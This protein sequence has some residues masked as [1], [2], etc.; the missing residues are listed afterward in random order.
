M[1]ARV[2]QVVLGLVVLELGV[3]EAPEV[4][5]LEVPLKEEVEVQVEQLTV[6]TELRALAEVDPEVW[7]A[8]FL[9][10]LAVLWPSQ[11]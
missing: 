3:P 7:K 1:E 10:G 6:E 9:P 8:L 4:H 5:A 11:S 2:V